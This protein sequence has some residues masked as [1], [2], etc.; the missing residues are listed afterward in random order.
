[1]QSRGYSASYLCVTIL[2]GETLKNRQ[3]TLFPLAVDELVLS[4]V[5]LTFYVT[6]THKNR[7]QMKAAQRLV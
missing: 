7:E 5:C 4:V 3:L 1:M 6:N 2:Q